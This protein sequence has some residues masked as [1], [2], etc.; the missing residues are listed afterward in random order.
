MNGG[1]ITVIIPS[2][3]RIRGLAAVITSLYNLASGKNRIQYCVCRD[4]DDLATGMICSVI[5]KDIPLI[6]RS[7]ERPQSLGGLVN[8]AADMIPAD[9]Y[10]AL[11]DDVICTT[12]NWDEIII[13]AAKETPHGVFWWKN[14]L[15]HDPYYVVVTEKWR[16]A[17]GAIFTQDYPYWFDDLHL[18]ELWFIATL[19]T[20]LQIPEL[21]LADMGTNTIRMRELSFWQK[22]F[23]F[24]RDHRLQQATEIAVKLGL[25]VPENIEE[26]KQA[27]KNLYNERMKSVPKEW[28]DKIENDQGDKSEPDE[29][30]KRAKQ[31][32]LDILG[33]LP[34]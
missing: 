23:N 6:V 33:E 29:S 30:Y 27:I 5:G 18:M 32:A 20:P 25:P 28:L 11:A 14:C 19:Q 8:E 34:Q 22:F 9:V 2:R 21:K 15:L 12:P 3:G 26:I 7:G 4:E 17:A 31:R 16:A 24:R 1:V 10:T 13:N